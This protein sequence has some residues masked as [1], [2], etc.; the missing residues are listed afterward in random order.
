MTNN[1]ARQLAEIIVRV[2]L[3][4]ASP[5]ERALLNAWLDEGE[6]N[7][8]LFKRIIRGETLARRLRAGTD[9]TRP[10]D[11]G[12]VYGQV[13]RRLLARR[14]RRRR[15]LAWIGPGIAACVASLLLLLPPREIAEEPLPGV[16]LA[17]QEQ[18]GKIN[19]IFN[20]NSFNLDNGFTVVLEHAPFI[21]K[22][23]ATNVL[24]YQV[25]ADSLPAHAGERHTIV[26][27]VGGDY[28]F[29]LGDGTRVWLNAATSFTYPVV[30]ARDERVVD[31]DG[32]AYFEVA[33]DAAHPFIVRAADTRVKVLGTSFNVSAYRD[34]ASVYTTTLTGK[35]EV[36]LADGRDGYLPVVL[37][38]DM[39]SC[40]NRERGELI[41]KK[42]ASAEVVSWRHGVFVFNEGDVE[43]VTRML[44]RWYG[45]EFV[46][47]AGRPGRHTFEGKMKK[48][49]KLESILRGLTMAGGPEFRREGSRVY[50]IE[51]NKE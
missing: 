41:V 45:V 39:Q 12:D 48:E 1:R 29:F 17:M 43:V 21:V 22:D 44:S 3:K 25:N 5:E 19:L 50:V 26:T 2:R 10:L 31:L 38:Q 37:T 42:V 6:E 14:G 16:A 47:E 15:R 8:L 40:W 23:T 35:V 9:A 33:P 34:E 36:S 20:E 28:S 18:R 51:R 32:E 11:H 7:R 46:H 24:R 49:E 4:T 30:F 13:Y 27:E